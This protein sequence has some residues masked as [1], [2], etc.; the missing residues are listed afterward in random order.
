M[1]GEAITCPVID[2]VCVGE[3]DSAVVELAAQIL[4]GR[5]PINI[6]NFW[7]KQPGTDTIERNAPAPFFSNLDS[8]PFI[9]RELWRPWIQ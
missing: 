7:F 6:H 2:A 3:E 1:P 8:L 5:Q 4:A 9:D